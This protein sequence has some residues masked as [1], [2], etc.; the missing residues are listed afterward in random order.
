MPLK[1]GQL[2]IHEKIITP[3]QLE[4]AL[5]YHVIYGLKLGS[6]LVQMGYVDE[7]KLAQLLSN[8]LD[9]PRAGQKELASASH[10][11]ITKLSSEDAAKYRVIP[12]RLE[13]NRLFVAMSDPTDFKII[14]DLGFIT[15][16]IINTFIAPD[17]LISKALAKFYQVSSAEVRYQML[18]RRNKKNRSPQAPHTV[19]F[20]M[21]SSSG[22]L[23]NITVPAEFEGFSSYSDLNEMEELTPPVKNQSQPAI[24]NEQRLTYYSIDQLSIDFASA[25]SRE[26]IADVFIRY[27]GQE[28][29]TG[30]IFIIFG[31]EAV[32][33]RGIFQGKR[34]PGFEM[35]N[36]SLKKTS[37]LQKIMQSKDYEIGLLDDNPSNRQILF[38][39]NSDQTS[40]VFA[41]PVIMQEEVVAIILVSA[42][43]DAFHAKMIELE[44][45]VYKMSLAF[46]KLIIKLKI[47]MT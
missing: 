39:L 23:I 31:D 11:A 15:G 7:E 47:L 46:E 25:G 4:E 10:E 20:P 21:K 32:G 16:C 33:W 35:F 24:N 6:S 38:L 1:L 5:K 27:L 13:R 30:A 29:E 36:W 40:K 41:L 42:D 28:F 43:G 8:K 34:M 3:Q 2:L 37:I 12:L 9:V 22:E 26:D 17:I 45:L 44:K 18:P 19:T 14:E